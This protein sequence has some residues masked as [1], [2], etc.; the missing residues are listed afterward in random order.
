MHVKSYKGR[1]IVDIM[2]KILKECLLRE[3]ISLMSQISKIIDFF[4]LFVVE[5]SCLPLLEIGQ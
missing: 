4:F 5:G 3:I 2:N 1:V